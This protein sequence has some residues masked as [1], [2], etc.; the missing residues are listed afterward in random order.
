M[1]E[2]KKELKVTSIEE[3][4]K[5]SKEGEI[6]ELPPFSEGKPFVARLQRPSMMELAKSGKIPNKLLTSASKLFVNGS[7][8]SSASA[9]P[10][11]SLAHLA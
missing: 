9:L 3:L 5:Y 11:P 2:E 4:I 10:F 7:V 8:S 1:S 6:V